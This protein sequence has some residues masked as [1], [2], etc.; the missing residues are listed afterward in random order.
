MDFKFCGLWSHGLWVMGW[1]GCGGGGV[2][3]TVGRDGMDCCRPWAMGCGIWVLE[4]NMVVPLLC[5][6]VVMW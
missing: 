2:G 5:I 6:V 4:G 3:Y 1:C